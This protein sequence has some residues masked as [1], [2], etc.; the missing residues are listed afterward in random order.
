MVMSVCV[1]PWDGVRRSEGQKTFQTS[2]A[3]WALFSQRRGGGGGR[4]IVD[5][6][7]SFNFFVFGFALCVC[8]PFFLSFF[9]KMPHVTAQRFKPQVRL[10]PTQ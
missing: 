4:R 7:T 2:Q 10:E 8:L 3:V 1:L 6:L 9:R 5:F